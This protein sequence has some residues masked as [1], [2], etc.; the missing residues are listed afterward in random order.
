M[1]HE[2]PALLG[3]LQIAGILTA[4]AG[5]VLALAQRDFGRL[6]GYAVLSD[7]GVALVAFGTGTAAGLSAA[8]IVVFVRTFGLGLM[9]M[10]L[11]IA[12]EKLPNDT[13]DALTG[14]AWR[15]PWA[16][17]VLII[18][19]FSLAGLP[20]F[21]GFAGRWAALQ[22]V[23]YN[24]LA[25][26]LALLL[27]TIG[28]ATGTLRGLQYLFQRPQTAAPQPDQVRPLT[29]MLLVGALVLTLIIGLFPDLIAP[30]VRQM[31]AAYMG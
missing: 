10:G 21:A 12:R 1:L 24:D 26:S 9:S 16:A 5:G 29:I 4:V 31:V 3:V 15:S 14:L 13:F 19:G 6:M 30:A 11:A 2:N 7:I 27:S 25:I 23:A 28:V 17:M 8:L 22:Q 20:P 18:G